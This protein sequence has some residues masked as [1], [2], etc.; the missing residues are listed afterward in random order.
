MNIDAH[1]HYWDPSRGD[2]GW[3]TPALGD[4]HRIFG[5]DDLTPLRKAADIQR[6][7]VVQAAPTLAETRYLLDLARENDSIAGVIGW[8]PLD[9]PDARALI[10]AFAQEPKFKGVRPMLQ[11]LPN[12][13]WIAEASVGPAIAALIDA[14]LS[15]DALVF[16]RHLPALQQFAERYSTLRIVI[17]HSAK[18][19]IRDLS[20]GSQHGLSTGSQREKP[21]AWQ[22][23]AD[24]IASLAA[25]PQRLHCKLSGLVTEA[26]PD[27]T[28]D[29]LRPYVHHL[30]EHFGPSRLLWGSDWPVVNMNGN[31]LRWHA[32]A[33]Q[34]IAEYDVAHDA[35][36]GVNARRFYRV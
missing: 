11:D 29:T 25:L 9:A 4:L 3:L 10:Q 16:T 6:T 36:F 5:P 24:A 33:R 7:I 34:L 14:D 19:P 30:I 20:A 15:F 21:M 1:Q 17:D 23:W 13:H 12:D 8:V 31:Y 35:I 2:Y 26:G 27:W 18:P 32:A 28:V 22:A